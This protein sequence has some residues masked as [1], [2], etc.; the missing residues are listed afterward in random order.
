MSL[1]NLLSIFGEKKMIN[2]VP[3]V[4]EFWH[5][6]LLRMEISQKKLASALALICLSGLS[7]A[8]NSDDDGFIFF[9]TLYSLF[10]P[11]RAARGGGGSFKDRKSIGEIGYCESRMA[12]RKHGWI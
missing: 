7:W 1:M 3:F 8:S 12:K 5:L 10:F 2:W 6:Q 4:F 9:L 11:S